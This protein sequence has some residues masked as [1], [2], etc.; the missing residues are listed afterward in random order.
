MYPDSPLDRFPQK[1]KFAID[2]SLGG[3]S[4]DRPAI[5]AKKGT[6]ILIITF[7]PILSVGTLSQVEPGSI[8]RLESAIGF[9]AINPADPGRNRMFIHLAGDTQKFTHSLPDQSTSVVSFGTELIV[10]PK[11]ETFEAQFAPGRGSASEL[12]IQNGVPQIVFHLQ[13]RSTRLLD[14]NSGV[15]LSGGFNIAAA[16]KEWAIG[17]PTARGKFIS[18]IK[19][20]SLPHYET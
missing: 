19:I 20:G 5:N 17:V 14:L 13:D 16:F 10:Q 2:C 3:Y 9:V 12:L 4:V 1:G 7:E 15:A 8:V 6:G 18:L 11:L